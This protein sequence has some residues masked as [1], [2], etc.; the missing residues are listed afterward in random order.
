[1][2]DT[3]LDELYRNRT[4]EGLEDTLP[5]R[6]RVEEA[7]DTPDRVQVDVYWDHQKPSHMRIV[8]TRTEVN[9]VRLDSGKPG[10]YGDLCDKLPRFFKLRGVERFVMAPETDKS[11]DVLLKRGSWKPGGYGYRWTL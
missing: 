10:L 2:A 9:F 5:G 11:R 6:C 1:M 4:S 7:S 8:C 3:P